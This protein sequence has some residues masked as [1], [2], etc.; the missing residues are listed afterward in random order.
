MQYAI[1]L[2]ILIIC[3]FSAG[4]AAYVQQDNAPMLLRGAWN[5]A[6]N[7][8]RVLLQNQLQCCG[9]DAFNKTAPA[10]TCVVHCLCFDDPI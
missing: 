1:I 10:G 9:L 2:V 7:Y 4:V 3:Q 6:N 8:Q 5:L